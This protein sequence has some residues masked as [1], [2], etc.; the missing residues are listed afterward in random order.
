MKPRITDFYTQRDKQ[1]NSIRSLEC[2][3]DIS[4]DE[5]CPERSK[6]HV[7]WIQTIFCFLFLS[8]VFSSRA[9]DTNAQLKQ[10]ENLEKQFKEPEALAVYNQLL[11]ADPGNIKLAV[12]CAELNCS[13]GARQ[14]DKNA[15]EQYFSHAKADADQALASDSNNADACYAQAIAWDK[16]ASIEKEN[17][18]RVEDLR[19]VHMHAFKAITI[20]P[21]HAKANYMLGK[22]NLNMLEQNWLK[23]AATNTL[24]GK[25]PKA[26]IDTAILYMEK[27][28]TLEP[29]FVRN[30]LDLAKAYQFKKRPAEAIEVLQKLVRLPIR[31]AD[32]ADL[33]A[34][35]K[36]MLEA[37]Q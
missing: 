17:K 16:L 32:D 7:V 23:K 34:E 12:K 18:K 2:E 6:K 11:T 13:I 21:D 10:A 24:Y 28:R 29:Y 37:M 4:I 36:K 3:A 14:T 27:C 33:K 19:Q 26:D 1:Q 31:T 5:K 8:L 30:Y 20:N 9:Q 22:W 15:M 25:F 35:G